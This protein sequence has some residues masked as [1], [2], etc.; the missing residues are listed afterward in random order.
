MEREDSRADQIAFPSSSI[1][2]TGSVKGSISRMLPRVSSPSHRSATSTLYRCRMAH[3]GHIRSLHVT[4]QRRQRHHLNHVLSCTARHHK[5]VAKRQQTNCLKQ[6]VE[7]RI[8]TCI[9]HGTMSN[10]GNL[11]CT[12]DRGSHVHFHCSHAERL[13][14]G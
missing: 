8:I 12:D 7:S 11:L 6:P 4:C 3:Q 5:Y 13:F 9:K 10:D 2:T 1:T 14:H